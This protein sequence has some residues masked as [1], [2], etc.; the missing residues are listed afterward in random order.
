MACTWSLSGLVELNTLLPAQQL[1]DGSGLRPS[2]RRS[3]RGAGGPQARPQYC[4][5][6]S[7]ENVEQ[8]YRAADAFSRHDL[9]AFLAICDPDIELVSRHLELDGSGHLRG[10]AAVRRWWE[11]L[12]SVYP[13]FTSEIEDVRDLGDVTIARHHFRGQG[14]ESGA[15]MEQR[16]WQVTRWCHSKADWWRSCPTEAEALEVAETLGVSDKNR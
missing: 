7:Q 16:Q 1:T 3:S 9:D 8:H 12:L 11:T 14:T 2:V 6:V 15:Q 4:A 13:D 10:H 5:G